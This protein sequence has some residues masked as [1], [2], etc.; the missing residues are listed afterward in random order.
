MQRSER[1][2]QERSARTSQKM[3]SQCFNGESRRDRSLPEIY[4]KQ[5]A[6]DLVRYNDARSR[7][8][9]QCG[10]ADKHVLSARN[11]AKSEMGWSRQVSIKW[12]QLRVYIHEMVEMSDLLEYQ[13]TK[14][15]RYK[16]QETG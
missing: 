7:L 3:W 10:E 16:D 1:K 14:R 8:G 4:P 12:P 15:S 6:W 11:Q 2:T 9:M 13:H 5:L